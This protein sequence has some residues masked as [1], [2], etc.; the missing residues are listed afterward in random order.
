MISLK[1]LIYEKLT[2]NKQSKNADL[3]VENERYFIVRGDSVDFRDDELDYIKHKLNPIYRVCADSQ[4]RWG[5]ILSYEDVIKMCEYYQ[6]DEFFRIFQVPHD[7]DP[8]DFDQEWLHQ[9]LNVNNLDEFY[10]ENARLSYK[11][12]K[13]LYMPDHMKKQPRFKYKFIHVD[14]FIRY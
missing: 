12:T 10:C 3:N 11:E 14:K 13:L 5:F 7:M 4:I 6:G 2:L 1:N 8:Y 9:R